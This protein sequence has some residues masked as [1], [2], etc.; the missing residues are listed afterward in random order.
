MRSA[1][2]PLLATATVASA[3][4]QTPKASFANGA[5]S[6]GWIDF[7]FMDA[8][9]ILVP[10]MVNGRHVFLRVIDGSKSSYIDKDVAQSLGVGSAGVVRRISCSKI[11]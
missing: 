6:T 2:L 8:Q 1:L 10:A 7:I 5:S 4:A 9:R 3:G 11:G